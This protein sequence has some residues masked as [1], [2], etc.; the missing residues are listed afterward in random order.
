MQHDRKHL[1]GER[2]WASRWTAALCGLATLGLA[3]LGGCGG[4]DDDH[5]V[6]PSYAQRCQLSTAASKT[7]ELPSPTGAYCIGKTGFHLVDTSREETNTPDTTDRRELHV[8]VWYPAAT[9]RT[10]QR[11]AYLDPAI[12]A[13]VKA[14][15]SLPADAPDTL[16]NAQA[17]APPPLGGRYPVVLFSPGYAAVVE[18]YS[19]MLEDLAS[20]GVV[21]VAID[22]PYV[23]G[24]TPLSSGEIVQALDLN[25]QAGDL[26]QLLPLLE[27]AA[28]TLVGDQ[29][30]VLDWLHGS[31][32]GLL[33][34]HVDL[35]RI[36]V[37]GHS[38]GGAAALQ[39]TR[40]DE[41]ARAG[42]NIDGR[43][44]GELSGPWS[45]P[46]MFLL[47]ENHSEDPAVDAVLGAATGPHDRVVVPGSGHMDFSDLKLLLDF[48]VP[49]HQSPM[50]TETDLGRIEAAAALRTTRE[51]TLAFFRR[52]VL[53]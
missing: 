51:Q 27:K 26:E 17:D 29:R 33:R 5:V 25:T 36:G 9:S 52:H 7:L 43:P 2:P 3:G 42:L 44:L 35:T 24:V 49:D 14:A 1:S 34:G 6:P 40:L 31:D 22:H 11:A 46:L 37:Y 10:G 53:R 16:T 45:K 21:V 19:A 47:A 30:H 50:W 32:I 48:H 28:S 20:Q 13:M 18:G 23:S 15:L 38:I 4:S 8:K 39:T 41:R 12:G